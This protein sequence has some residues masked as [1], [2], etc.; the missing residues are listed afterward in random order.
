MAKVTLAPEFE[1]MS[2]KLCSRSKTVIALNHHTGKMVRYDHHG[3]IDR[4]TEKQQ[5]VR[6]AFTARSQAASAWWQVNRPVQGQP[7]TAEYQR[8]YDAFHAQRKIGNI[9]SFLR[10]C[11]QPDLTIQIGGHQA[12]T[13]S[14]DDMKLE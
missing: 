14:D 1:S 5:A 9:Y 4:N 13:P 7:F 12:T 8:L 11:V 3:C 6:S 10:S 2:G